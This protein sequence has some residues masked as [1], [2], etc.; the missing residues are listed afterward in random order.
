[1]G[2]LAFALVLLSAGAG[3]APAP[4]KETPLVE[5]RRELRVQGERYGTL[6]GDHPV[7]VRVR[8]VFQKV[9]RAAGR[10]PGLAP[11]A[12]VLDTPRVIAEALRGGLV[13]LSR[14]FVD[15]AGGD[16]NAL[17][18]V[19][20]HEVAHLVRDHHVILESLGVLGAGMS[21]A[22]PP[23]DERVVRA[24]Q[25]MELD[26]DRLGVLFA[27]LAGY[28]AAPAIPVLVAL[29]ERSGPDPFH[30]E[31]TKRA[32]AIREQIAEVSDHLEVFHLGLFLLGTG[33]YLEAARVLEHFLALFPSREVLS[34][35]GVAYH[36]EALRYAPAP[37]FRHLLVID[38]ATRALGMR[39]PGARPAFRQFMARALHYYT[40]AVDADPEYAPALNNLAAAYLDL[41]ER[42]LALGHANR[43]LKLDPA[44][45][46]AYNNRALAL[47]M[48]KDYAAAEPDLLKAARLAPGLRE[49]AGNLVRLYEVQS[50]HDEARRWMARSA[51]AAS[52]EK[53][54]GSESVGLVKPGTPLSQF[55]EWLGESGVR[56]I[57]VP[58]G[59]EATHDL[60][61][62]VLR[63]RGLVLLA[64]NN[65]VEAV[66]A[67]PNA[68]VV[69]AR[70]VRPGDPA[71]RLEAAYGRAASA[72]G[73]QA[74]SLR[75]YPRWGLA[76]FVV[77]DRV[78][79][80][81]AGLPAGRGR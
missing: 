63:Q 3:D 62:L 22:A 21:A 14:G 44:L 16:D 37:E 33:R 46:S 4:A 73:L 60:T 1:M 42:D 61:L 58:L 41:G 12:H 23:A 13:V 59:D 15:L 45:A 47:L 7:A 70:G 72:D 56:R 17:A 36:K 49:I 69:T 9:V 8:E 51:P 20:G 26:A 53:E 65:V 35:V 67:L 75:G 77:G 19:L 11:E 38:A 48:T 43:A 27:A 71:A 40:L 30:P 31:P 24:Y 50:R 74:M 32:A 29:T 76:A 57:P 64:R 10:R 68:R 80:I 81:W 54:A 6:A 78:Q 79:A 18:F 5:G 66:G 34:A 2:A 28:R 52:G 55:G 25:A 39:G